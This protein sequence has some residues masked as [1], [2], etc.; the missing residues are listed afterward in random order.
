[1]TLARMIISRNVLSLYVLI[2]AIIMILSDP[3]SNNAFALSPSFPIQGVYLRPDDWHLTTGSSVKNLND[4]KDGQK[5]FP[6]PNIQAVNYISDG[7][8]LNA[9]IWLSSPFKG[10]QSNEVHRTYA[11]FIVPDSL[12]PDSGQSYEVTMDWDLGNSNSWTK[13]VR[14]WSPIADV[15]KDFYQEAIPNNYTSSLIGHNYIDLSLNLGAVGYPSQYSIFSYETESYILPSHPSCSLVDVTAMLHIPPPE[16]Q[17]SALPSSQVLRPDDGY[18]VQLELKSNTTLA[19]QVRLYT[20]PADG[21]Q[22]SSPVPNEMSLPGFG[23]GLATLDVKVMKNATV[24][25][26][27]LRMSAK[28]TIPT[29][30]SNLVANGVVLGTPP[31]TASIVKN[32]DFVITVLPPFTPQEQLNN[33]LT[34]WFN[35]LTGVLTT[36]ATFATGILGWR[37]GKRPNRHKRQKADVK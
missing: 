22:Y 17:F 25:P 32:V 9:T 35:P 36:I 1:M 18:K 16:F 2:L 5:H 13:T 12:S 19:S 11:V 3:C 33:F 29:T 26:H 24:E 7:K 6:F 10:I 21:I 31:G 37:I 14:E 28:I 27:T 30:I 15:K 20:T 23:L 4:C 8:T 34:G